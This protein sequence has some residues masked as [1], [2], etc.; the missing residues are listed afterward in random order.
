M[1]YDLFLL[2]S[3]RWCV[4]LFRFVYSVYLPG[5]PKNC[6]QLSGT[7]GV[8]VCFHWL[9]WSMHQIMLLFLLWHF[10]WTIGN[11]IFPSLLTTF[12]SLLYEPILLSQLSSWASSGLTGC[13]S[14]HFFLFFSFANS[15]E[16]FSRQSIGQHRRRLAPR[17]HF[18]STSRVP[19]VSCFAPTKANYYCQKC[20]FLLFPTHSA[21]VSWTFIKRSALT[22]THSFFSSDD[23]CRRL[24]FGL[25][26]QVVLLSLFSVCRC[27]ST[28][29]SVGECIVFSLWEDSNWKNEMKY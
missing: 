9:I 21:G 19:F 1:L 14:R 17:A 24:C 6:P 29:Q 11:T 13:H 2:A 15:F 28:L 27:W 23:L 26:Q 12:I 3:F 8:C 5:S 10:F 18:S 20:T 7:F 22:T 16:L 4:L 25:C